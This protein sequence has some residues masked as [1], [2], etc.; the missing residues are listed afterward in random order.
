MLLY[1]SRIQTTCARKHHEASQQ[2]SYS[3]G[4]QLVFN[5]D[6]LENF[7]Q[8]RNQP[9]GNKVTSTKCQSQ[10][11][12]MQIQCTIALVSD[13]Q[14]EGKVSVTLT[15]GLLCN[16]RKTYCNIFVASALLA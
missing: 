8:T 6:R 16:N 11:S 9:V 14:V 3:K 5:W 1:S 2:L 15:S 13:A 7:L 12:H 4:G 10:V